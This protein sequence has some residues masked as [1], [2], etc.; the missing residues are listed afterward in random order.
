VLTLVFGTPHYGA[1]LLRV[2]EARET[3]QRYAFFGLWVTLALLAVYVAAIHA[4]LVGSLVLTLYLTWSPWHYSGQNYGVA[5]AFLR[6]RG[7]PLPPLAKRFI[8]VSFVSS[9]LLTLLALHSVQPSN[10]YAPVAYKGTVYELLSLGIPADLH[11]VLFSLCSLVYLGALAGGVGLLLRGASLRQIAP[12][13]VLLGTQGLW[14]ALPTVAQ[15]W[16][17]FGDVHPL[18]PENAAY[19]FM[20]VAVGHFIQ[21][22]WF[23][24]YYTVGRGPAKAR[25][26]YLGKA[27]LAGAAIWTIPALVFAPGLL[28][29]LPYDAGLGI[30]TAAVV[31]LH[32]FLLD[33]AIWK[34]RDGRVAR[35]LL[36]SP[37]EEQA[38][39]AP[40]AGRLGWG[41]PV[42]AALGAVSLIVSVVAFRESAAIQEAGARGDLGRV[43]TAIERFDWIGRESP[44]SHVR[45]A[46]IALERGQLRRAEHEL[47]QSL[48]I[49]PTA[50][51]WAGL[52][53]VHRARGEVREA[54]RAYEEAVALA[55]EE[56][57]LHYRLGLARLELSQ[58]ARARD[59]LERALELEPEQRL[60]RLKLAEAEAQLRGEGSAA[61]E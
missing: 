28:G 9:F 23:T 51:A 61:A 5:L 14:F 32:H 3:R 25:F 19:T 39:A 29:R 59:A 47:R 26:A 4:P 34:L 10:P 42:V 20:W 43:R 37:K 60:A 38:P 15:H 1:T 18:A 57:T 33:G 22:L 46:R 35:V 50:D 58:P 49:W 17:V 40:N 31:N 7:V 11:V 52:A 30:M 45:L 48:E 8:H 41:W 6:R 16:K 13:A 44:R 54:A 36:R 24:T 2:Y 12:T 27:L 53:Q 55:P 21:Y 56:P